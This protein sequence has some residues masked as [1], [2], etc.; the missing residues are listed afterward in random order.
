[1]EIH[2]TSDIPATDEVVG[3]AN[4][5]GR[6]GVLFVCE[7][8]S[9][10]I[11]PEF[12]NLGLEEAARVSHIAW[13]PGALAVAQKLSAAFDSPLVFQ[14]VSRLV[15]DCNRPPE[16]PSAM[17]DVSEI[18]TIP[19]NAGLTDGQRRDRAERFYFPFRAALG[20]RIEAGKA[21]GHPPVIVTIHSFTPV[22]KG[23]RR[24][25]EIGILHDSDSRLADAVLDAAGDEFVVG[26]NDPYGPEDG[27]THTL[28]EQ[29]VKRG[30]LNVMIEIRNDLIAEAAGID[31]M[32]GYLTRVL[33]A[34]IATVDTTISGSAATGG[35]A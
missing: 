16:A 17:P 11:P 1:M 24:A 23:A 34:A 5:S 31:T 32:A 21:A 35:T 2:A 25:V 8:A 28:I 4:P 18:F 22:Y 30:L 27:V 33:R 15:Y 9:S 14:R 6:G 20:A 26:R 13:D 7:H 29:G 10:F 3:V 19:G 12:D